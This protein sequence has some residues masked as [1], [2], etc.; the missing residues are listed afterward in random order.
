MGRTSAWSL[1]V[2]AE[3]TGLLRVLPSPLQQPRSGKYFTPETTYDPSCPIKIHYLFPCI[4]ASVQSPTPGLSPGVLQSLQHQQNQT[5]PVG[6]LPAGCPAV[7]SA[8]LQRPQVSK[9]TLQQPQERNKPTCAGVTYFTFVLVSVRP[10]HADLPT[11]STPPK[12]RAELD[13]VCFSDNDSQSS[14]T[15]EHLRSSDDVSYQPNNQ[16]YGASNC[17]EA[18]K[19]ITERLYAPTRA[20][21]HTHSPQTQIPP[22]QTEEPSPVH[23]KAHRKSNRRKTSDSSSP[24][25]GPGFSCGPRPLS[26]RR[27]WDS[28]QKQR[29]EAQKEQA[30]YSDHSDDLD[31]TI[32]E[33]CVCQ[34]SFCVVLFCSHAALHHLVSVL[35]RCVVSISF[36]F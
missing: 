25:R 20:A 6:S 35:S 22:P 17:T 30:F 15:Q 33:V 21:D 28:W 29:R 16:E 27:P 1:Q 24:P 9:Q 7:S 34:S 13:E 8:P 5:H 12:P 36:M 31:Q 4:T 11:V 23:R 19:G 26:N 3:Q 32:E 14:G 10:S 18:A 2:S